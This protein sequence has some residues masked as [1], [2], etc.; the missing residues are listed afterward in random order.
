MISDSSVIPLIYPTSR[1]VDKKT[2]EEVQWQEWE[3]GDRKD[4]KEANGTDISGEEWKREG[5]ASTSG[6]RARE[7]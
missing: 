1:V 4:T 6:G 7:R 3:E 5:A 2:G